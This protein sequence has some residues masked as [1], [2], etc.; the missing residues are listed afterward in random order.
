M[1]SPTTRAAV[2][3]IPARPIDATM[4]TQ[5]VSELFDSHR[6]PFEVKT[7]R[8]PPYMRHEPCC[9]PTTPATHISTASRPIV[10]KPR[11]VDVLH[12]VY[13][14]NPRAR[15]S[16]QR[17]VVSEPSFAVSPYD[18]STSRVAPVSPPTPS[19][20]CTDDNRHCRYR[21][22][23][24]ARDS[25]HRRRDSDPISSVAPPPG[26]TT[27]SASAS[28][29]IVNPP[30]TDHVVDQSYHTSPGACELD[31]GDETYEHDNAAVPR[32]LVASSPPAPAAVYAIPAH[33]EHAPN[34]GTE[35][36]ALLAAARSVSEEV[37]GDL[38]ELPAVGEYPVPRDHRDLVPSPPSRPA[39]SAR[40]E[41]TI[42]SHRRHL[43]PR[44]LHAPT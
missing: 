25:D 11:S 40:R 36:P 10:P 30:R 34:V 19:P 8:P 23:Y 26:F 5:D 9:D 42:G 37:R 7:C 21:S 1:S 31:H 12:P 15:E 43:Q 3:V 32:V 41:H 39:S 18:R 4:C 22:S 44:T 24:P 13:P 28:R 20:R 35:S 27:C 16:V 38:G 17:K 14:T 2:Y 6:D 29:P 33:C